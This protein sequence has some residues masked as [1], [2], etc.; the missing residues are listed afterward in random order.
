LRWRLALIAAAYVLVTLL[1]GSRRRAAQH[2]SEALDD[3]RSWLVAS[4]QAARLRARTS[5]RRQVSAATSSPLSRTSSIPTTGEAGATTLTASLEAVAAKDSRDLPIGG[6]EQAANDWRT[7]ASKEIEAVREGNQPLAESLVETGIAKSRFDTVRDRLDQLDAAISNRLDQI[8]TSVD[9]GRVRTAQAFVVTVLMALAVTA[10]AAVLVRR[11]I[12]VPLASLTAAVRRIRS[13]LP[14]AV[15]PQ[16]PP[17]LRQVATAVDEMQRTISQQRDDAIRAREAIEQSAIL[18]LQVRSELAGDLGDYPDGWTMA[19]GLRAAEGIVA[20]DCYDVSLIS[21]TTIGIV[22]LDIAGHGA[23]SAVAALKCKELLKA[24]LRSG[25]EPGAS[26]SWL[27]EQEHGLGEL[28]LT[29]FIAVLDTASGRGTYGNAGHPHAILATGASLERLGP[30]GPIVGLLVTTWQTG[31]MAVAPGGK[32]IIYTDGLVEARDHDRAFYGESRLMDLLQSL[33]CREAQPVVD[34][35][36]SDLDDFHPGRLADD[37]TIVVACRAGSDDVTEAH[38]ISPST[39]LNLRSAWV[40]QRQ[41]R[42]PALTPR[43][44]DDEHAQQPVP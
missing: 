4:E 31:S 17:E 29:A 26:L 7:E 5:T 19:A 36:L 38:R 34:R 37:V 16:G 24:A 22:V 15:T 42:D 1:G 28:F 21:P 39:C 6:V 12:M 2:W 14:A 44:D 23:Q 9:D 3:R 20:G 11:W 25:L 18:A 30:T 27:S 43:I 40:Q 33:D 35:I 32:L 13:G 10:V 41:Q 8:R